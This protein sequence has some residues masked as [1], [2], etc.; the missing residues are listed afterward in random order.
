MATSRT[1]IFPIKAFQALITNQTR[2]GIARGNTGTLQNDTVTSAC[3][4]QG[5]ILVEPDLTTLRP[6]HFKSVFQSASVVASFRDEDGSPLP[7]CPRSS[8][9]ELIDV[10]RTKWDIDFQAGFEIELVFLR[11]TSDKDSPYEPSDTNHAWSTLTPEQSI[12]TLPILAEIVTELGKMDID[13][14][15]FHSE[16][17]PGQYE[18]VLP[19]LPILTAVDALV[20]ARQV[21]HEIAHSH[22]LRATLHPTPLSGTGS[23]QHVHISLNSGNIEHD[24][25]EKYEMSFFASVLEHL[26]SICAFSLPND[27]SYE[28][29]QD[30]A[31][32]G[33]TWCCWGTQNREVP[34]RRVNSSRWE[35]RCLDGLANPYLAL[36]AVLAAGLAG[37]ESKLE[38][39]TRDCLE[40]PARLSEEQREEIGIVKRMPRKLDEALA[41]LEDDE[42]LE[43]V[44]SPG[45]TKDFVAMK[46][47]E[48]EMLDK[49]SEGERRVWLIERY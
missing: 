31:W 46:R 45:L 26:P 39:H 30:D 29:V 17:G 9:Q 42:V 37:L 44:L 16:S 48:K 10:F 43:K 36:G 6:S 2:I 1:R 33:G 22:G 38:M 25:L 49:M 24:E 14:L 32:T 27:V 19:P 34:L 21:M 28:R 3:N 47:A 35:I 8:L 11:G 41:A 40:N 15:Q 12:T 23:G 18:L 20:T 4:P 13:I 7:A 5:Q